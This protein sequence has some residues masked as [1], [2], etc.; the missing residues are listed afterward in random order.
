[1]PE[2]GAGGQGDGRHLP[3][4]GRCRLC[5]TVPKVRS[6]GQK[7][8]QGLLHRHEDEAVYRRGTGAPPEAAAVGRSH[9]RAGPGGAGRGDRPAA[10]LCPGRK[11]LHPHLLPH[12]Q[13]LGKAV[14]Y[15]R[16]SAQGQAAA[17]RGKGRPAGG[18]RSVAWHGGAAG[19]TGYAGVRQAGHPLRSRGTCAPGCNARRSRA[20]PGKH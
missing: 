8:V 18:I 6:A 12:R 10:G 4:L 5:G 3:Q 19:G 17:L 15:H 9:Q 11:P 13:R 16:L 2:R 14:R 20:C 1:M 7:A